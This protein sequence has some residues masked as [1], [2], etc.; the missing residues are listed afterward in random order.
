MKK[1]FTYL[2]MTLGMIVSID[3]AN[4]QACTN[5]FFSEY[6]EGSSNNKAIEVYNPTNT[7]INLSDYKMYRY[8]NGSLTPTDS[9]QMV[10]TLAPGAVYVAGNP[11]AIA[12]IIN[13]SDTLH[14]ITFYNG[15]DAMTLKKISTNTVLDIIGIVGVDPGVNWAVGTGATSEFTLVRKIGIN[16][17]NINWAIAATEWDVYP[18]NTVTFIGNHTMTSC[19]APSTNAIT[20]SACNSY[21]APSGAIFTS[22]GIFADTIP[23]V[24]GCDSIITIN[25]IIKP[26]TSASISAIACNTYTAPSGNVYTTSGIYIDTIPNVNGCDSIITINLT[27]KPNTSSAFGQLSCGPY[28]A[29]SGTIFTTSGTY[30]D[31]IPNVSGCDSVMTIQLTIA[32]ASIANIAV[33]AC[34]SFVSPLGPIYYTSGIYSD[35]TKNVAGCD[36]IVN[37]TVTIKNSTSSVLTT[38]S[39]IS[40]VS[41]AGNAYSSSGTYIDTIPNVGGCD[42]IITI[43]LTI[44]SVVYDTVTINSCGPYTSPTGLVYTSSTTFNDTLAQATVCDSITTYFINITN[45][46]AS[47]VT[48]GPTLVASPSGAT[49]YQWINCVTN[50]AIGG[51][52]NQNFTPSANGSYAV[53][54]TNGGCVDTSACITYTSIG[55]NEISKNSAVSIYPNPAKNELTFNTANSGE[56]HLINELGQAVRIFNIQVGE[57]KVDISNIPAG[58][59]FLMNKENASVITHKIIVLQQ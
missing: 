56:F 39:C 32:S 21:T 40:Y 26:N 22:S 53:V 10:G 13:I 41:P 29:P 44:F 7:T 24:F 1:I 17:G 19:C 14:T 16:G 15:D 28:T 54:V 55:L 49:S 2:I 35:T 25:L 52:T 38:S 9:L 45:V 18:Q 6:L 3:H 5:L 33:S 59:Y 46:S 34:D 20:A 4:A 36:S 58:V 50:A 30:N 37:F 51:A 47:I 11:S 31:T 27:I 43:N 12:A 48:N 57:T 8:N 23:N 42:S